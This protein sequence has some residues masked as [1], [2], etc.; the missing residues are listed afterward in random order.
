MAQPQLPQ[1]RLVDK[2]VALGAIR[3]LPPPTNHVILNQIAPF[4]DVQSDDVIF[5]YITP[6][7]DGLAPAS[8]EDAEAELAQ[9]DD[10]VG[11]GSASIAT[12]QLKDHYDPSDVSRYREFARLAQIAA[13]GGAFPLTIDRMTEDFP[14]KLARD[15]AVRRRKLDNRLEWLGW[16]ALE[17]GAIS[18]NDG[19]IKFNVN[20]GRPS[21]QTN[22]APAGSTWDQTTS[23]PIGDLIAVQNYMFDTYYVHL[24]RGFISRNVL[25]NIV[26]SDKFVARSG[27]AVAA[28]GTPLDPFYLIDNWSPQAALKVIEGATG[29]QFQ[30]YDSVYRT[31]N[32]G[33]TTVVNNRFWS[34]KKVLLLPDPNDI[35]ELDDTQIGFAKTL[36]SPHPEGDWTPG[37]YEWEQS[38]TDP[39]GMDRGT[40]IKAFPVFPHLELTYTMTVLP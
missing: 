8:S 2:K 21:N 22:Q 9:K 24:T 35:A 37:Y 7:V 34:N 12:W 15:D 19:K 14:S 13:S 3:E 31:R 4:L 23:D 30:V 33:S 20:Y 11:V 17:N 32:I 26:K 25:L 18:Y 39:W 1:D 36:T 6:E 27:L 38:T 16:Q 10:T 28:G 40:G 29:I 5:N